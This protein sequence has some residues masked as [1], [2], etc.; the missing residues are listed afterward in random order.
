MGIGLGGFDSALAIAA[1]TLGLLGFGGGPGGPGSSFEIAEIGGVKIVL[2]DRAMPFPEVAF[3]TEMRTKKVLYPGNPIA[4]IQVLGFD[5][6]NTKLR[7]EWNYRFLS[8]SVSVD[9]NPD[10]IKTP[11][12]LTQLFENIVRGGRQVRVQWLHIVRQGVLKRF[13]PVWLR[14]NDVQWDME[15][16]WAAANDD[17]AVAPKVPSKGF[18][19]D[20]LLKAIKKIEDV[21]AL[22]PMLARSLSASLVSGIASIRKHISK[23][24]Q[25]FG[26]IE[27]LINLPAAVLGAIKS[28]LASIR[29]E[30]TEMARRTS[31]PSM[32][33]RPIETVGVG[34]LPLSQ[35]PM[36]P[37]GAN[38]SANAK[39]SGAQQAAFESWARTVAT[40]LEELRHTALMIGVDLDARVRPEPSKVI[41]VR[42]GETLYSI[43]AREYGSADYATYL[44]QM[45]RLQSTVPPPGFRLIVPSRPYGAAPDVELTGTEVITLTGDLPLCGV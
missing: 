22:A 11:A 34:S 25:T 17:S 28:A 5:T 36:F 26:A 9:G 20:D 8:K 15:F 32:G 19:V 12:Q 40:G 1:D 14:A 18:G 31:G 3:P 42:E 37:S 45:N 35:D 13:E 41:G 27:A 43:A 29:D 21:L 10:A 39:S 2:R 7:G 30:C 6:Q 44:L 23:L 16:E 33:A 4:T 24:I 38:G